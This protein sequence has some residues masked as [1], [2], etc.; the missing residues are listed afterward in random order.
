MIDLEPE[1][2]LVAVTFFVTLG[3]GVGRFWGTGVFPVSVYRGPRLNLVTTPVS[4]LSIYHLLVFSQYIFDH[5]V[6]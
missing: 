2:I 5:V 6:Q 1:A 4:W 3:L